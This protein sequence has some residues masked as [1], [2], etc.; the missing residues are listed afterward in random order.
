MYL[1]F[2]GFCRDTP[3]VNANPHNRASGTIPTSVD[4][5][6]TSP[7]TGPITGL[8]EEVWDDPVS[9]HGKRINLSCFKNCAPVFPMKGE[10][11]STGE[12]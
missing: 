2:K 3:G 9:P 7:R 12:I 5:L 1:V 8:D 6:A 10:W 11:I 4:G